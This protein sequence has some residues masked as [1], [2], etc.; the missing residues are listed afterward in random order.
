MKRIFLFYAV[1]AGL[2]F[3]GGCGYTTSSS[4]PGR[5]KTIYVED[6]KNSIDYTKEGVRNLYLPLLEVDVRNAVVDR[7]LF[8]GNLDIGD[9][10]VADLILKAELISYERAALR[11]TD[12]DDIEEYRIYIAVSMKLW[13]VENE[14]MMW[15]ERSFIGES[16]YFLT[17]ASASSEEAAV[18][19]AIVDLARRIVERTIEN[20]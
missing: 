8:D 2:F 14:R 3:T 18:K 16:T 9:E 20:W 19:K 11:Y 17:G 5:L 12:R 10:D 7:F 13:D 6:F 15:E 4:L 1:I